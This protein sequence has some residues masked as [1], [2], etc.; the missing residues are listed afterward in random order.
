MA[1]DEYQV[2]NVV[3][4]VDHQPA[5]RDVADPD[6]ANQRNH[7]VREHEA[8]EGLIRRLLAPGMHHQ[9]SEPEQCTGDGCDAH[10]KG[11]LLRNGRKPDGVPQEA[12]G[13]LR[14]AMQVPP[15]GKQID[16]QV[17]Q[18]SI[19]H[20]KPAVMASG[21]SIALA[22]NMERLKHEIQGK[23]PGRFIGQRDDRQSRQYQERCDNDQDPTQ[24]KARI[25]GAD[26]RVGRNQMRVRQQPYIDIENGQHHRR[27][28]QCQRSGRQRH[29]QVAKDEPMLLAH[30]GVGAAPSRK[31]RVG[32]HVAATGMGGGRGDPRGAGLGGTENTERGR[33]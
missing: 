2:L 4:D 31:L 20:L 23:Q 15:R 9:A 16:Q 21:D 19:G 30:R 29:E 18:V 28:P 14:A 17:G 6:I 25:N 27:G 10:R 1:I 26:A 13:R 22:S 8:V 32:G 12:L 11:Q 7:Q 33:R 5:H 24:A 3:P